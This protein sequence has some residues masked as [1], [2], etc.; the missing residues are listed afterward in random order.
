MKNRNPIR[1]EH[2]Q[3]GSP[4]LIA[5]DNQVVPPRFYKD[6]Y[7][8]NAVQYLCEVGELAPANIGVFAEK[9]E[10]SAAM[11]R[12]ETAKFEN[13]PRNSDVAR[14]LKDIAK[15]ANRLKSSLD[16]LSWKA[17]SEL[18]RLADSDAQH[19]ISGS[20]AAPSE[21]SLAV[22][23]KHLEIGVPCVVMDVPTLRSV[24]EGLEIAATS[25]SANLPKGRPGQVRSYGLRLWMRNIADLWDGTTS[26]AFTR[27]VTSTGE[28]ITNAAR[29]CAEAFR[30]IDPSIPT[31]RVMRE[32]KDCIRERA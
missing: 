5:P 21:P 27:D 8:D 7:D 1:F 19:A 32:L 16:Q 24:I 17:Q 29:F 25:K 11:Y 3:K 22:S 18:D 14:E 10:H 28:P 26:Q 2:D 12:W 23:L 30:S 20:L 15:Q 31:S 6:T 9:L 4:I 13:L